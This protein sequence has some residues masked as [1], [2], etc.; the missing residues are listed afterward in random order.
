MKIGILTFNWAINFG[1]VLQ[2]YA[3]Y[4]FLNENT[5]HEIFV[6]NY[7]P[8]SLTEPYS[9]KVFEKPFK[10]KKIIKRIVLK[11]I[12][13]E[14]HRK[15]DKF[16]IENLK[17]TEFIEDK[18]EFEKQLEDFDLIIV[19][20]DQVWNHDITKNNSDEY[21]L[22]NINVEKISY[23]ASFGSD[24]IRDEFIQYYKEN[25]K[26]FH[27]ISLREKISQKTQNALGLENYNLSLD[28]VFLLDKKEWIRLAEKSEYK[29][30]K[31]Q[32]ILIYM[33]EKNE[34][35]LKDALYL[36]K[37][38]NLPVYSIEIIG[39]RRYLREYNVKGLHDLGP[40]DFLNFFQRATYIL[41]N[42]FHGVSFSLILNKNF[43]SYSHSKVNS[44]LENILRIYGIDKYQ[45]KNEL[46]DKEELIEI[47]NNNGI[48]SRNENHIK[49][50]IEDSKKYLID[51]IEKISN[52]RIND[53]KS[54]NE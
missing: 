41:T 38:Y 30:P 15:F 44:R 9:L 39:L 43:I 46:Q 6:I 51:T 50:Y 12:K 13:S 5:D 49:K 26:N 11:P 42:S 24:S 33:L 4:S 47:L 25:L 16:K 48:A 27:S 3:L 29:L 54:C 21:L 34:E 18:K 45:I 2:M 31:N 40:Y 28:P 23:A 35:L 7:S 53:E 32:F 22:S 36:S 17:L 20:S 19:G 1:A 52:G 10:F 37:K 8:K 14:Q